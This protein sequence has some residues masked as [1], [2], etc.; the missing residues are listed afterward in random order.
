MTHESSAIP[1][2]DTERVERERLIALYESYRD[3]PSGF[4]MEDYADWSADAHALLR[5]DAELMQA[6]GRDLVILQD[7]LDEKDET[8]RRLREA[9]AKMAEHLRYLSRNVPMPPSCYEVLHGLLSEYDAA[10]AAT[11]SA[12]PDTKDTKQVA[13]DLLDMMAELLKPV[14]TATF[15]WFDARDFVLRE[16]D[17]L[18]ASPSQHIA[19]QP[20][21]RCTLCK[22]AVVY[23]PNEM[24]NDCDPQPGVSDHRMQPHPTPEADAG[25]WF[26]PGEHPSGK[27]GPKCRRVND[28]GS[29]TDAE[30]GAGVGET[31]LH[32][33]NEY[34]D[35]A[36]NGIQYLLNVRD[37]IST[38]EDAIA[39]MRANLARIRAIKDT[40]PLTTEAGR[41]D[42]P[43]AIDTSCPKCGDSPANLFCTWKGCPV[44]A[45]THTAATD[46][47]AM[48]SGIRSIHSCDDPLCVT[49]GHPHAA[50]DRELGIGGD[51]S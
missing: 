47:P 10:L 49:C 39:D 23:H 48:L 21:Y 16:Y 34:A 30:A 15:E 38:A 18:R 35:A 36:T 43:V 24:C 42:A 9:Q 20:T 31:W 7:R 25:T 32:V 5:A 50:S 3:Q 37:G 12:A 13:P 8:I 17:R 40:A 14:D 45:R 29:P 51:E 2:C 28:D 44:I 27:H 46:A 4:A 22:S 11:A 6:A 26:C 19:A 41:T 33:A 1:A